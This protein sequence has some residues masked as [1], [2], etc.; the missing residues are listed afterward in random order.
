MGKKKSKAAPK[1]KRQGVKKIEIREEESW[2]PTGGREYA[3]G[4]PNGETHSGG[5]ARPFTAKRGAERH[6]K[7]FIAKGGRL[8]FIKNY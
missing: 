7:D 8:E 2:P 5:Y 3:F 6:F 1:A 4:K